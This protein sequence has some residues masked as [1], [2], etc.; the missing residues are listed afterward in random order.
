MFVIRELNWVRK[1]DVHNICMKNIKQYTEYCTIDTDKWYGI[2][3]KIFGFLVL[4]WPLLKSHRVSYTQPN[5]TI[6]ICFLKNRKKWRRNILSFVE[7]FLYSLYINSIC[8]ACKLTNWDFCFCC[9]LS[10][11]WSDKKKGEKRHQVKK[12]FGKK[13]KCFDA[14]FIWFTW[15]I[16]NGAHFSFVFCFV[17]LWRIRKLLLI[18][19]KIL[20]ICKSLR[21]GAK[22]SVKGSIS[23]S[24]RTSLPRNRYDFF[25]FF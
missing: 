12:L 22:R 17:E 6:I 19:E 16:D 15:E 24:S 20:L 5:E 1:W 9:F 13:N 3:H 11:N 4:R 23:E 2:C 10:V 21:K 8:T 18:S 25:F 7:R 14:V